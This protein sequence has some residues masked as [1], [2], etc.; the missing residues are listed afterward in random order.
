MGIDFVVELSA[1]LMLLGNVTATATSISQ[2]MLIDTSCV[3]VT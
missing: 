1:S 3:P 2:I